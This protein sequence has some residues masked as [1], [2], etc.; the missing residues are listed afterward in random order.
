MRVWWA[1]T[2]ES[3]FLVLAFQLQFLDPSANEPAKPSRALEHAAD[4]PPPP[5]NGA[6]AQRLR[7]APAKPQMMCCKNL[8]IV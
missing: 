2:Q 7:R 1:H 3:T 6:F 8:Q 5:F 4:A